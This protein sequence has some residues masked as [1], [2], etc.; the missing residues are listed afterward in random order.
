MGLPINFSYFDWFN[1]FE[2]MACSSI[3]HI[4]LSKI[5]WIWK[6]QVAGLENY[7]QLIADAD[8]W[9]AAV[10]TLKYTIIV[11][12]LIMILSLIVASLLNQ[13]LK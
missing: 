11:V 3:N 5:K 10:N 12:P 1:H 4:E 9:Q 2:F 7:K 6:N 8:V 13:K